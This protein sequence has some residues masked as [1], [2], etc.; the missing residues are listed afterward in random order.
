MKRLLLVCMLAITGIVTN[1]QLLTW[2][3]TFPKDN[4]VITI[5]VDATKGNQGLMGFTG[6]VYVHVGAITS[7][8]NYAGWLHAPFTWGSTEVAA[9]ATYVSANKWQYTINNPRVFFGLT[10]GE[11]LKS[12]AILFRE[13]NCSSA[14][15]A[16]RNTDGSDMYVPIYNNNLAVRIDAPPSQ[17]KYDPVPE[18]QSWINGSLITLT[19]NSSQS[20]DLKL[21]HNGTLIGGTTGTTL[22]AN[23][24]IKAI[25]NQQFIVSAINGAISAY[26]TLNI[27][28]SGGSSPVAALPAGVRDGINYEPGDTSVTLVLR[29]PNKSNVTVMG[30]FNNW[31]PQASDIMNKTPDGKFFWLRVHPLVPGRE[32]AYQYLVDN[33]LKIADPYTEKV[34]DPN[35]DGFIPAATYPGL[36]TYPSGQTGIVSL[37][38]TAS[39]AYNWSST[40]TRPDKRGLVIYEMLVRDFVSAHDWKTVMDSL[41]YLKNLGINAVQLMPLNE[42]EGN[43]SWGYNPDFY[44]APDKYYGTRNSLKQFIDSCHKKGIAVI[45]DIALNHSFGQ[46]PMVQLYWDAANNRPAADNPWFNPVAKH[47]F[48]VGYDMN[49]AS[50]D[51]KYF[52]SR[53]VEH[54]L[55]QYRIDGFRFDLSKGFTQ[56]QTCDANGGNCNVGQWSNYDASR[57]AIW[58][59]YYDTL[60]IKSQGS[61]AILE[62]FAA[63]QEERELADYGM[64]LWGNMNYNY[65]Q[66]SMGIAQDWDFSR[67]IHTVRNFTKPHL[68][69]YMESHDEERIVYKNLNF[70]SSSGSY[71]IKDTATALKRMELSA[72]FLFTIPGPKMI[73]QFGELGYNYSINTCSDGSVSNDCRLAEK[74]IRWDY[75]NDPRR[76]SVYNTYSQLLHLRAHPWYKEAF[77]SGSIAQNLSGP[78]KWLTVSSGDSSKLLVVGNFDI[79]AQ[80]AGITFPAAGTWFDY[81]QNSTITATGAIQNMNLSPGEFHVYVNRNVN[82][83]AVTPVINVPWTGA[84]LE[85]KV[86]PNPITSSY[87]LEVNLPVAGDLRADL[88]NV[89]GQFIATIHDQFHSKGGHQ[90]KMNALQLNKGNYFIKV[91]SKQ[92]S[93]T[94]SVTIQ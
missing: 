10:P 38:Q 8:N 71:N 49:H 48:N 4:D 55:Q 54:W 52:V 59:G 80:S 2:T 16:Q 61:Y 85:A 51:T 33:N 30:E 91:T 50:L 82:N 20:A 13:G 32:Y 6:N 67:A 34:L 77:L 70:G 21:Y 37:L 69:S 43:S 56:T 27:F 68:V 17:P 66:A 87:M 83:V 11:I 53:V 57:V 35:S 58:K 26:D 22:T 73:W 14:C 23:S 45:M 44:F 63:D 15:K 86:Y 79:Y 88:Y 92:L 41:N 75:L 60:Q 39:P 46:S 81:L 3:P 40:F 1:A 72:S 90:L 5:T 42:F 18:P 64:M 76:K 65:G 89:T 7:Q 19:A 31:T 9:Q 24:T 74:P 84:T 78:V 36:K 94:I 12:I 47:A 29:A 25:G 93:K 28:V 62:H